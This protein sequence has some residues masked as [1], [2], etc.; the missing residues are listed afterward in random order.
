MT[1]HHSPLTTHHSPLTTHHSPLRALLAR[2]SQLLGQLVQA[3]QGGLHLDFQ[4][5]PIMVLEILR[6]LV[7]PASAGVLP[8]SPQ[9][10][11]G[12][13]KFTGADTQAHVVSLVFSGE[14]S[15]VAGISAGAVP[16]SR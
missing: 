15:F 12:I 5:L 10:F 9:I 3:A 11:E 16:T 7:L 13:I 14:S 4:G 8:A 6:H 1:T 2:P